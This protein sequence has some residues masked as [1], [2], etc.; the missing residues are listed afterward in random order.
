MTTLSTLLQ[1]I[2]THKLLK[3]KLATVTFP[4]Q[5][6]CNVASYIQQICI[7]VDLQS[8]LTLN[9]IVWRLG[10]DCW[11]YNEVIMTQQVASNTKSTMDDKLPY[12]HAHN[13]ISN[14]ALMLTFTDKSKLCECIQVKKMALQMKP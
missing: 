2:N 9:A 12:L 10:L 7:P 11:V 6:Y 14:S 8:H 13:C 4:I 5:S 1:W 3:G